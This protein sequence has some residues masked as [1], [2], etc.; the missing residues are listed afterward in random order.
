W[1]EMGKR[2]L[3][4]GAQFA[5]K[6]LLVGAAAGR[7]L[8]FDDGHGIVERIGDAVALGAAVMVDQK[9]ARHAG[10]PSC[11]TAV[12]GAIATQGTVN[13]EEDILRQVFGFGA[14]A[15]KP[16]T[17]VKDAARMATHKL[18]P[19]GAVSLEALLDQLGILLQRKVSLESTQASLRG[20]VKLPAV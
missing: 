3:H 6:G 8:V 7:L 16:I 15:G 11:K 12:G 2:N 5:E 18:L 9:V 10:H 4:L 20:P 14:I 13:P 17:D 1:R 19:G